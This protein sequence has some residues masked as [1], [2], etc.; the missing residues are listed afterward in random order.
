MPIMNEVTIIFSWVK[1]AKSVLTADGHT[2]LHKS[3][4]LNLNST[5]LRH[6]GCIIIPVTV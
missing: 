1:D 5:I 3:G 4:V 6:L 2:Q